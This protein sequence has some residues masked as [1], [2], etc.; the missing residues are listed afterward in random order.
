MLGALSTFAVATSIASRPHAAPR[1]VRMRWPWPVRY[2]DPHAGNDLVAAL[3]GTALYPPLYVRA[4]DGM[5]EPRLAFGAP[6]E[7]GKGASKGLRI[8][9]AGGVRPSDVV[10][11]ITA[12]RAGAARL[13]LKDV[14][15]PRV[16]GAHGVLF[17]GLADVDALM[18]RLATPLAGIARFEPR[19]ISPVTPF[20]L[21]LEARDGGA[22]LTVVR[23]P[24]GP[25]VA[26]PASVARVSRFEIEG[27]VDLGKSLR[28][29]ERYET[30]I[31]WLTDG[32]FA[33]RP[34]A[35][36]ID[37]GSLAYLALR[38]GNEAPELARPGAVLAIVDA[39]ASDRLAHLGLF[40]RGNAAP[41]PAAADAAHDASS[42]APNVP[43]VVR[44]S[45]PIAVA[46]AEI[47]ARELGGI[48][49]AVDDATF[50]RALAEGRYPLLLEAVR[51]VDDSPEGAAVALATFD[52]SA[53]APGPGSTAR[54]VAQS[55]SAALGWEIA[56]VGA[57]AAHVWIPRA[58]FGGFDLDTGSGG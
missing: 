41:D 4:I 7:S 43:I 42:L 16:D 39:I 45:M 30:D 21:M 6:K 32:L 31:G 19:K 46:A 22:R 23:R 51:A 44:A 24:S 18:R 53:A 37:L 40:R 20:D 9:L 17:L 58:P 14:P 55:G 3:L 36:A 33:P 2:P 47:L 35:R 28:A 50:E 38:A 26:M 49:R 25:Q 57:E 12:A 54:G 27:A 1:A 10:A 15:V 52:R 56:L 13:A 8:D 48:A 34:G 29:F 11:S 5:L